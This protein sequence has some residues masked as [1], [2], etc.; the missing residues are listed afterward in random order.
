MVDHESDILMH[1]SEV[2]DPEVPVLSIVDLGIVK[3][4][5][6]EN[7]DLH[8]HITPTY[9]GCPAM[10]FIASQIK[11]QLLAYGYTRVVVTEVLHPAWTT[12]WMT[13]DGKRKLEEYGIAPPRLSSEANQPA[14]CPRCKSTHVKLLAQWGST[15]CKAMYQCEQCL[16]PFDYFKCY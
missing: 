8:I 12:E 16:E 13:A 3:K 7:E 5:F 11:M 2:Y 10:Q 14:C 1:L 6:W 15:S 4:I 9:T